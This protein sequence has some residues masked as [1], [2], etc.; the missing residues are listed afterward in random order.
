MRSERHVRVVVVDRYSAHVGGANST[1]FTMI[2]LHELSIVSMTPACEHVCT[3]SRYGRMVHRN[4][5]VHASRMGMA[6]SAGTI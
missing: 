3:A 4:H 1:I 5:S 6:S 2:G